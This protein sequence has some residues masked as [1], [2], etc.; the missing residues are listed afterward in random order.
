MVWKT[1]H[2]GETTFRVDTSKIVYLEIEE[3]GTRVVFG[4]CNHEGRPMSIGVNETADEIL[5]GDAT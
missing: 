5:S 4:A 1:L 2:R 3:H